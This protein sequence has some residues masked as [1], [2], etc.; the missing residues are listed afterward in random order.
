MESHFR[1]GNEK[2]GTLRKNCQVVVFQ[3]Y[4]QGL[5]CR[6]T[7]Y[8]LPVRH[9]VKPFRC[10]F[11]YCGDMILLPAEYETLGEKVKHHSHANALAFAQLLSR[12]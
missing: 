10:K 2:V 12:V 6:K 4:S 5:A 7:L 1:G 8:I 3:T 11:L 9:K